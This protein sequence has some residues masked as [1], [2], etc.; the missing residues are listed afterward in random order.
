LNGFGVYANTTFL[1][2][3]G[4]YDG[5]VVLTDLSGFVKR[6]GNIGIS[7]IKHGLTVR[8]SLNHVGLGLT[9]YNNDPAQRQYQEA[10]N[11]VD[12]SI[13]YAYRP[14]L[15]VFAD[16]TNVFSE[17]TFVY[18]GVGYRP[19]IGAVYGARLTTGIRGSF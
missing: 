3:E 13:R 8:T 5:T 9:S 19:V 4:T 17:K 16:V 1:R 10:R 14:R 2:T 6:T 18:Q 7:Y 11:K 12:L 15:S